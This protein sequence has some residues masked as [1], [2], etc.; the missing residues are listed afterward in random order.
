MDVHN[1]FLDHNYELDNNRDIV[2]DSNCLMI[3]P[4]C[5]RSMESDGRRRM[6]YKTLRNSIG[7]LLKTM[8]R[9]C[10]SIRIPRSPAV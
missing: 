8:T 6:E 5:R 10:M 3:G 7:G 1:N 2:D 4:G 9:I